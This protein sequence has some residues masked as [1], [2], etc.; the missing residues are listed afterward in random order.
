[1]AHRSEGFPPTHANNKKFLCTVVPALLCPTRFQSVLL[2]LFLCMIHCS[3]S[4]C[5]SRKPPV[6]FCPSVKDDSWNVT[7][8]KWNGQKQ[9]RDHCASKWRC[10]RQ[11]QQEETRETLERTDNI[12]M[13]PRL[14]GRDLAQHQAI[15]LTGSSLPLHPWDLPLSPGAFKQT[16][17]EG[18]STRRRGDC[19]TM[20]RI[21]VDGDKIACNHACAE[22]N[23]NNSRRRTKTSLDSSE[24]S[25][26]GSTRIIENIWDR[27][28]L[29][30]VHNKTVTLDQVTKITSTAG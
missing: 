14:I 19:L 6:W 30:I 9:H 3:S 8:F 16:N 23:K 18:Q 13:L 4:F 15:R 11:T 24:I 21:A 5:K 22:K 7:Y 28:H 20:N 29:G 17:W 2:V 25:Q 10:N 1:M 27:R 12:N 26:S